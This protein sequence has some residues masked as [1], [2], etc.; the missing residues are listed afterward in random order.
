MTKKLP[1]PLLVARRAKRKSRRRL[2]YELE[3]TQRLHD[4]ELSDRAVAQQAAFYGLLIYLR[5]P[6]M[7]LKDVYDRGRMSD[8]DDAPLIK[9]VCCY[10]T[11]TAL[12]RQGDWVKKRDEHWAAVEARVL[13]A[14]QDEAVKAELRDIETLTAVEEVVLNHVHGVVGPNGV[15]VI[16]AVKPKSLEGLVKSLTELSKLRSSKRDRTMVAL[17]EAA[18]DEG[19]VDIPGSA[20]LPEIEDNLTD[21]EIETLAV[22][23]ATK[24]ANLQI[25]DTE[26]EEE[27]EEGEEDD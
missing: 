5:H 4:I 9:E 10:N 1:P 3:A 8:E 21:A 25:A 19:V 6:G 26:M 17:T 24:R 18:R 11:F 15:M 7:S 16:E 13:D 20:A 12:S 23:L 14:A 27:E 22:D 2:E